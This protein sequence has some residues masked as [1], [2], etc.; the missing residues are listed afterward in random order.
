MWR[1]VEGVDESCGGGGMWKWRISS[2][3]LLSTNMYIQAFLMGDELHYSY[4][5]TL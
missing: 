2:Q 3:I 5:G 4:R 1:G